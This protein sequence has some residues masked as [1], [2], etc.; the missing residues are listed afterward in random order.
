MLMEDTSLVFVFDS[1]I[2]NLRNSNKTMS[3]IQP[4]MR[5][6]KK[7]RTVM[8]TK[9]LAILMK[10]RMTRKMKRRKDQLGRKLGTDIIFGISVE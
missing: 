6:I 1:A 10:T 8:R 4:R 3:T 7:A 2:P 5:I 9:M